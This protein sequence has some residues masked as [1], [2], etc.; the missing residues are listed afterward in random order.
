[1]VNVS[2]LLLNVVKLIEPKA[3]CNIGLCQNGK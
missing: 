2:E 3:T 1:M